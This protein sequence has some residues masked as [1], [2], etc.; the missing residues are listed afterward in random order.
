MVLA[1]LAGCHQASVAPTKPMAYQKDVGMELGNFSVSLSVKDLKVS[2]AFYE[3]LGFVM[4]GGDPDQNWIILRN[5]PSII[6]LFQ[7]MF[8]GNMLTFNPGWSAEAE[9]LDEFMDIRQIQEQLKQKGIELTVEADMDSEG[10]ANLML[11]DPDGNV[12]LVDQH[13]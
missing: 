10:P 8:E 4:V 11:T 5:G 3:D 1:G 12:I 2:R 9:D 6:G 13:R 7:G